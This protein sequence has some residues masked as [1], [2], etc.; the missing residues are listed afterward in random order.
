[1]HILGT[2]IKIGKTSSFYQKKHVLLGTRTFN[3]SSFQRTPNPQI[4]KEQSSQDKRRR[5]ES[6]QNEEKER[7]ERKK[8]RRESDKASSLLRRENFPLPFLIHE[9]GNHF[10][11]RPLPGQNNSIFFFLES[12]SDR[13]SKGEK[14]TICVLSFA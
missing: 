1:M 2:A 8:T 7:K 10:P 9:R 12:T 6:D 11:T 5:K 14:E 3:G 4:R 13:S